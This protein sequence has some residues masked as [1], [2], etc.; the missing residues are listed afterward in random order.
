MTEVVAFV[1]MKLNNER[2]PGKNT[3]RFSDG[4][5]LFEKILAQLLSTSRIGSIYVYCSNSDVAELLPAGV[6]FLKRDTRLDQSTTSMNE[7]AL[8]FATTVPADCYV[9]AHATAPFLSSASISLAVHSVI[10]GAHDSAFTVIRRSEFTWHDGRPTNYNPANI[11]RTQDLPETYAE[12]SGVYVYERD[13]MVRENR[14]IGHTPA[15]IEVSRIEALDIDDAD[16]FAL[17][18]AVNIGLNAVS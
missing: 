5:M 15:L 4:T 17:A 6:K 8:A 3:R 12:T 2:L 14:R 18:N 10:E 11:P 16:D 9:L 13:L 1:P 7:V